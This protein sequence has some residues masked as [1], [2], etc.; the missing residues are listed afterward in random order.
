MIDINMDCSQTEQGW[1]EVKAFL[2]NA[3]MKLIKNLRNFPF[4]SIVDVICNLG[5][6]WEMDITQGT[7]T[8]TVGGSAP[9]STKNH[10]G[11]CG[12]VNVFTFSSNNCQIDA[13]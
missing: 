4:Y 13:F 10:M 5:S 3:G 1:F 8:G 11:R 7:C 12:Y 2:T 9:Y 6:G